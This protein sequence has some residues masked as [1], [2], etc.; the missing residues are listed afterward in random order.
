LIKSSFQLVE[1]VI[2]FFSSRDSENPWKD[3]SKEELKRELTQYSDF[4]EVLIIHEETNETVTLK[5]F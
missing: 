3:L 2:V 4:S 5:L 1:K